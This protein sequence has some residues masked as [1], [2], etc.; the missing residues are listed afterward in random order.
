MKTVFL[1]NLR[2]EI[3]SF[4]K[5]QQEKNPTNWSNTPT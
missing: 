1:I 2:I 4:L 3:N 5:Q